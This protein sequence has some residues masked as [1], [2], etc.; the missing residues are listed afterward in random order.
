MS[1]V[2]WIKSRY[3]DNLYFLFLGRPLFTMRG[4]R[5]PGPARGRFFFRGKHV[6]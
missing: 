6:G 2:N 1:S 5:I 4:L 3:C